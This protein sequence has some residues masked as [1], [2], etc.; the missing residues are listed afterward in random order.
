MI[1]LSVKMSKGRTIQL[2]ICFISGGKDRKLSYFTA[3]IKYFVIFLLVTTRIVN[4]NY[5]SFKASKH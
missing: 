5:M 4:D 2:S 3:T 1:N